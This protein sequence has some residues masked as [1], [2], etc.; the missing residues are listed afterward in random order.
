MGCAIDILHT[1]Y[2][3]LIDDPRLIHDKSFMIH[4]YDP[5]MDELP[6]FK[7]YMD[8][9]CEYR[10]SHY[11]ASSK[12]REVTFKKL[13]KELFT[14]TY[15]DNQDSTNVLEKLNVIFIQ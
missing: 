3:D 6:E 1:A 12:T 11:A 10:T 13:I 7:D 4:I 2:N 5:L 9:Q 14:L 8:Y 15:R